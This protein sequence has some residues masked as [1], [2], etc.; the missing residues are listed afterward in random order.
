MR[1][2]DPYALAGFLVAFLVALA[3]GPRTIAALRALK[4]GQN[5]NEDAPESHR[6]KQ[7]TP[8]MGGVLLVLSLLLTLAL[9][10]GFAPPLRPISP[11]LI[12]IV[13]VFVAH[14]GLGFADDFLKARRGKSLG[15][16]ARQKLAGQVV[17]AL[18]FVTWLYLTAQPN[19]TTQVWAW[20][21][22]HIDLGYVYYLLAFFLIIGLSNAA[23]LTDG[24]DGLAG[25]LSIFTLVGL[26]L[27]THLIFPQIPLFGFALAGACLGFLWYNAHPAKV[28]MGDTGSLA[29]G[30]SFAVMG[31][32]GKQEVLL[33]LFTVVFLMEM[34]SVMIQVG[35]FKATGGRGPDGKDIGRRV[36]R[37]TPIHHH[38]EKCGWPETQ[39]VARF[40]ILGVL[41]LVLGLLL[42]PAM[43][44]WL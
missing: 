21:E 4:F 24:L 33:L 17:I 1:T 40:W 26:S 14:A 27:T 11:A 12:A 29:L 8:S 20:H 10:Y 35:V 28:F 16:L 3:L 34:V 30:S 2:P 13:L 18:A 37:M 15:L 31:I 19:F 36:F 39:V 23:N 22:Q 44:V 42:A 6:K 38:F 41:A 25:G 7:G 9:G 32:I 43:Y 5:I